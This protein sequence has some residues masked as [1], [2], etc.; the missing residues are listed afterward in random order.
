[1]PIFKNG[2]LIYTLPSLSEIREYVKDQFKNEIWE[3]ELRFEQ[4]H[5]HYLDM[6]PSY[7]EM[8]MNLLDRLG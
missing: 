4:P 2:K 7:Y 5:V 6:S 3:E 1:M 8:K